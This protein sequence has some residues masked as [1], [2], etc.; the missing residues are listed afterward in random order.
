[1]SIQRSLIGMLAA[2]TLA[3]SASAQ[4]PVPALTEDLA[5]RL[6]QRSPA[7]TGAHATARKFSRVVRLQALDE[8]KNQGWFVE[9]QWQEAGK[10]RTGVAPVVRVPPGM[11]KDTRFFQ[12]EGWGLAELVEDQD[13]EAVMALMKRSRVSANEAAVVGDIRTVISAQSTYAHAN[14]EAYD[15][16]RCLAEPA[17]C[18]AGYT[19]PTFLDARAIQLEKSGYRRKFYPGPK[20]PKGKTK[21]PSG[22]M[23]FAY[24][25]V[26]ITIGET[27][28]RGFCGDDSGLICVTADGSEPKVAAGKCVQPCEVLR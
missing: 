2:L 17:K 4:A 12:Q 6:I 14:G 7:F 13:I 28:T 18:M 11:E 20:A 23:S 3:T 22:V 1:M 9:V 27:G 26:P 10:T 15:E 8:G 19:G 16:L 24:T 25:A 5:T 21:S